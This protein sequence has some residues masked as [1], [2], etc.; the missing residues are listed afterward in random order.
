MT[1]SK[2]VPKFTNTK[3]LEQKI[4]ARGR[5]CIHPQI[6]DNFKAKERITIPKSATLSKYGTLDDE[7][8]YSE[9][10]WEFLRRNRFYQAKV[11][12]ATPSFNLEEWGYKPTPLHEAS[13]GI[14]DL[15]PYTEGHSDSTVKWTSIEDFKYRSTEA[16]KVTKAAK[17]FKRRSDPQMLEY[18]ADQVA[19]VFDL[20]PIFGPGTTGLNAQMQIAMSYL[21]SCLKDREL[22]TESTNKPSKNLLRNYLRLTDLLSTPQTGLLPD[23]GD[24][25]KAKLKKPLGMFSIEDASEALFSKSGNDTKTKE[26]TKKQKLDRT[27]EYASKAWEYIYE[28]KCLNL[29]ALTNK[30]Q[31][32]Q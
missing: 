7:T 23:S 28:W 32:N 10:A 29:I 21:E 1:S 26:L 20:A 5:G 13:F 22:S 2:Q 6:V 30:P 11:D 14:I 12:N 15:K 8:S 27:Y 17:N 31:N 9:Y 24:L 25:P 3:S 18:P 4:L 19:I 16:I